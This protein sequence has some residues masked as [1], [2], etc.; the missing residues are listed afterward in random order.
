[1]SKV[2]PTLEDVARVA[3][4]SRVVDQMTLVDQQ[5]LCRDVYVMMTIAA[6]NTSRIQIGHGVTVPETRSYKLFIQFTVNGPRS[7]FVTVN[8][9]APVEVKLDGVGNN[10]PYLAEI[11]VTLKFRVGKSRRAE[12]GIGMTTWG[13][14]ICAIVDSWRIRRSAP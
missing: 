1:M 7:Y 10:T 9:G 8:G 6:Q 5:N 11:P 12:A 2:A 14:C 13:E 3:G 4:V